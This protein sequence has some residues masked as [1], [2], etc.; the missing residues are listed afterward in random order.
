MANTSGAPR[1]K[2]PEIKIA[3][4]DYEALTAYCKGVEGAAPTSVIGNLVKEFL[5]KDEVKA[6]V[7]AQ[8]QDK[9]KLK[10]IEK[11]KEMIAKLQAELAE[12]EA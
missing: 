9:K 8:S 7:A 2:R 5:E 11:K 4:K 3:V 6:V 12:L 1:A 10:A